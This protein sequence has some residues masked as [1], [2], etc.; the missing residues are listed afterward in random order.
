[1]AKVDRQ[2]VHQK[3]NGHCSYC[4]TEIAIKDMQVDH[5]ISQRNYVW[6]LKNNH[7]IP[8]FLT[9]L[10][11]S[12]LNHLDNLMP[13]CR[14]CNGFKTSFDLETFR[15]EIEEQIKRLRTAKPTF[16]LAERFGLIECKP[17]PVVFYFESVLADK[18]EN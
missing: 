15:S 7:K 10:T 1:M 8:P 3:F 5:V 9:H 2:K 4:G 16:R 12:D 14:S 17:K 18:I 13:A 11:L 6:H